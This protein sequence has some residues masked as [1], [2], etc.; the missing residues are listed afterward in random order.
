MGFRLNLLIMLLLFSLPA[1][2]QDAV[3]SDAE[4]RFAAS[5]LAGQ[6]SEITKYLQGARAKIARNWHPEGLTSLSTAVVKVSLDTTG[7][8][9]STKVLRASKSDRYDQSITDF[10]QNETAAPLP[11]GLRG[12]DIYLTFMSDSTMNMIE[13]AEVPEANS[14]YVDLLGGRLS[15][16]GGVYRG[17]TTPGRPSSSTVPDVDFGPY[18]ADLQHRIKRAWFPPKGQENKKVVVV[19][20]IHKDGTVSN[21]RLDHSS[22]FQGAD[23][24]GLEAVEHASPLGPLPAGAKDD[25]DIQFTLFGGGGRGVMRSF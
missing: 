14:Y 21:L 9:I 3:V 16:S 15:H 17:S 24:A 6:R 7:K 10:L 25:C 4:E 11:A 12:L 8:V 20:K 22:G 23:Q 2:A 19:F 5:K 13:F 1:R 18:M